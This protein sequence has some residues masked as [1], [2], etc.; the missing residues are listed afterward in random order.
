MKTVALETLGCKVN[1]YESS[2]IIE[3]L[4]KDGYRIVPF[5]EYADI[6]IVHSCAVTSKAGFQTRQLLRRA[7]RLNPEATIAVVG[8]DA[9]LEPTRMIEEGLATHILGNV[10]KL[11][12]TRW[13]RASASL[14]NPCCATGEAKGC[15]SLKALPINRMHSGR[16][17]AFQKIQDGC[18][19]FCSYCVIPYTR[20]RSR[21]LPAEEVRVQMDHF[22]GAG[23]RE[24][25]LT[26]IHLGQWGRDLDPARNLAGLLAFLDQGRLP[27]RIRLSSLE[28]MEWSSELIGLLRTKDWI[29]PHFHIPLQS[30]DEEILKRMRRP[31]T[32]KK[33]AEL[34]LELR[35]HFP[36]AAI[37]ADVL[38]GFPGETEQQF[39]NTYRLLS[40]LPVDYLHVFPYS[41]RPG[42]AAAKW[43]GRV[44]GSE[45]KRRSQKLHDLSTSKR[46]ALSNR[47]IGRWVEV[48]AEAEVK[49][50]LWRGASAN[51]LQVLFPA[52]VTLDPGSL[53]RVRI[54]QNT[55]NGLL[56]EPEFGALQS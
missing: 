52:P 18:N 14:S 15:K 31:Y 16:A 13:L 34:I 47:F 22:L 42:T 29:C 2:Y 8:C 23:Y 10:E 7:Q 6:Y 9:E 21:S 26:G 5:S 51:Y 32:P 17:R 41:P 45:L 37:G 38:V 49:P 27:P 4:K 28:P 55:E 20:G 43:H 54:T 24:V 12:P 39:M 53:V 48:P 36:D 25:V 1:Q 40:D 19:A 3:E 46:N 56:G 35:L 30:G 11:D 50:G 33:Y 44:T